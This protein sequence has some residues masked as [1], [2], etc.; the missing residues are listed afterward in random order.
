[1]SDMDAGNFLDSA[2][3]NAAIG[4][5]RERLRPNDRR[6]ASYM[7]ARSGF[8]RMDF[9]TEEIEL[10][11]E[12]FIDEAV[13]HW[14][15]GRRRA[16]AEAADGAMR[17]VERPLLGA[18]API[19]AP[20]WTAGKWG[21]SENTSPWRPSPRGLP[22]RMAAAESGSNDV[23]P[24]APFASLSSEVGDV[25]LFNSGARVLVRLPDEAEGDRLLLGD[26]SFDLGP[27]GLDGLRPVDGLT[28]ADA[29][30]FATAHQSAPAAH[31]IV[32]A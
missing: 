27:L 25:N 1:M 29:A 11:R 15:E 23:D 10:A 4:Q 12:E 20:S 24:G 13:G 17:D 28:L 3:E 8:T 7:R 18:A 6:L 5:L 16:D 26:R 2:L 14:L 9:E 22:V 31:P 19:T 30:D 21:R 32:L